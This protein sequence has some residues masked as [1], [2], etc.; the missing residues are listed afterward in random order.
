MGNIVAEGLKEYEFRSW[1]FN[2]SF[3]ILI[4]VGKGVDK[5]AMK[6][7]NIRVW[8]IHNQELLQK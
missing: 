5:E 4:H 7:L 8:I 3:E 6:N 1:E 2:Y